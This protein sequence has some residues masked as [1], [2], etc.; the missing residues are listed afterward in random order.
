MV[1]ERV[2][3]PC[4]Q[5]PLRRQADPSAQPAQQPDPVPQ[6]GERRHPRCDPGQP[7]Q[8]RH[9]PGA[10]GDAVPGA[11]GSQGL[12]LHLGHVHAGWALPPARLAGHAQ[13]QRLRH[14]VPGHRVRAQLARQRQAQRVGP[15]A[16]QVLLVPRHAVAR[17]H[18]AG[19]E[20]AAGA[21]VVAHLDR[22]QHPAL[23]AGVA[24][25]VQRRGERRVCRI[26]R[27]VAEQAAVIH[28]RRAD[29][30]VRVQQ[31]AGVEQV[32]HR[33]ERADDA[34]AEH[35]L[36]ELAADDAVAVLAAVRPLV[37]AHQG[38]ALLGDGAHGA[39]VRRVLHVQDGADVQAAD[40]GV[41]VPGALGAVLGEHVV[42]ALGVVGQVVQAHGAVLDEG[43]RLPVAA[44]G[45][46]DVQ[47]GLPHLG[48][49]G[50]E[51]GVG[52]AHDGAGPAEVGHHGCRG[53]RAW[54]AAAHRHAR[55]TRRSAGCRAG[56]GP[57]GLWWARRSRCRG[58]G[59]SWCGPQARPPRA[60][61]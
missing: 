22:G 15:A 54:P 11:P 42:Q 40:A 12:D 13:G 9:Q 26:V 19:V 2:A 35:A 45:H 56:R 31:R 36:V 61:A 29:D 24:G 39:D 10:G 60:A 23:R 21:V 57:C 34:G 55:G 18:V 17:A 58:P 6:V 37:L 28:P 49:G 3:A 7:R 43:H 44:H 48:D 16:G 30:A 47:P 8:L 27:R 52:G 32:L 25:P 50:L 33:L 53:P 46:H 1:P 41:G 14:V 59:L 38:E 5:G 20:L 51:G 4:R